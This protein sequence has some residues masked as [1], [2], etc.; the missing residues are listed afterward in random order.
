M[1][2]AAY[3]GCFDNLADF[4][5]EAPQVTG[6]NN[7]QQ[8][9]NSALEA[10]STGIIAQQQTNGTISCYF[11][12]G[13]Q[14]VLMEDAATPS[15]QCL[16]IDEMQA[17]PIG[18][19]AKDTVSSFVVFPSDKPLVV[20]EATYGTH[21]VKDKA[22]KLFAKRTSIKISP[23]LFDI[24]GSAV[25]NPTEFTMRYIYGAN[26]Q[27]LTLQG[28]DGDT[29]ALGDPMTA[30]LTT[31]TRAPA[32][33]QQIEYLSRRYA[34]TMKL[35]LQRGTEDQ[36]TLQGIARELNAELQ[37]LVQSIHDEEGAADAK[38]K[39]LQGSLTGEVAR[40]Q[41]EYALLHKATIERRELQELV[42]QRRA[43]LNEMD[44][45]YKTMLAGLGVSMIAM[46]AFGI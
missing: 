32:Y 11:T 34:L 25:G 41:D 13:F 46:V 16:T 38:L 27:V 15:E 21:D 23:K 19:A 26:E 28:Q 29:V 43:R 8:C 2:Y 24:P 10:G 44:T 30:N 37:K 40:L 5:K 42:D 7:L 20:I 6:A 9:F 35:L 45:W 31:P 4:K 3:E 18:D 17:G 39:E 12:S 36:E 22:A 33:R 1:A 14:A